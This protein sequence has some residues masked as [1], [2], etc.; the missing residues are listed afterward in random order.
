MMPHLAEPDD[1]VCAKPGAGTDSDD[2]CK[3]C[4][5]CRPPAP[6]DNGRRRGPAQ[7][8]V[9]GH[10]GL[11][12]LKPR[13][14]RGEEALAGRGDLMMRRREAMHVGGEGRAEAW[15]GA[16]GQGIPPMR[17]RIL[18]DRRELR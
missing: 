6:D 1:A 16:R 14:D 3:R 4:G 12:G 18:A 8:L 9:D 17:P 10:R 11:T 15:P 5:H 13:A 2:P 7:R